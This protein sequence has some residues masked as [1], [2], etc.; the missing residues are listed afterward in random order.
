[1]K[2]TTDWE[3]DAYRRDLTIN[4]L[5]LGFDGT[6]FDYTGGIEDIK[7]RRVSFVGDPVTRL[8]EDY[9]RILRY[10]R[11]F[12]RI[13]AE[14]KAHEPVNIAA[15]IQCRDGLKNVSGERIW[16]ELRKILVGRFAPSILEVML[17]ECQLHPYLELPSTANLTEFRRVADANTDPN[18]GKLNVE[19]S[20]VLATL[21]ENRQEAEKFQRRTKC[22][23]AERLLTEFLVDRREEAARRKDDL[24]YFKELIHDWIFENGNQS[25]ANAVQNCEELLKYVGGTVCLGQLRA[26]SELEHFPVSGYDLMEAGVPKGP[27]FKHMLGHLYRMWK[28][29]DFKMSREELLEH[30]DDPLEMPDPPAKRQRVGSQQKQTRKR[31]AA[32]DDAEDDK[33]DGTEAAKKT[34][35]DG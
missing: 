23:N 24:R 19:P 20:T 14:E 13:A 30:T 32:D 5:F 8:Q 9:L 22:S 7:K 4:S 16:T 6:V 1:V 35:K 26:L 34:I 10:F 29:S 31:S 18:T 28:E 11:F 3:L 21:L 27:H 25:K 17:S 2:F 12:G 15:I 33:V